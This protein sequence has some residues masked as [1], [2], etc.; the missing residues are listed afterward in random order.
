M[1]GARQ[2]GKLHA[3]QFSRGSR[4]EDVFED[5]ERLMKNQNAF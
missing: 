1:Y 4:F 2:I 3:V 5:V